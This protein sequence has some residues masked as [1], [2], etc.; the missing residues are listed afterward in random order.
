M[1]DKVEIAERWQVRYDRIRLG[2]IY[3]ETVAREAMHAIEE[4]AAAE[5]RVK[6]LR[7]G[8]EELLFAANGLVA[9]AYLR[10]ART[11]LGKEESREQAS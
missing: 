6:V 5:A 9:E 10:D 7:E 2:R 4:L 1:T 8:L 11:A 3:P